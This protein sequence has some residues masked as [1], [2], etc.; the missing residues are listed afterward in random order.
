M[1]KHTS[2]SPLFVVCACIK[3]ADGALLCAR[4]ASHEARGGLWELP[5]GKV[6]EHE[7]AQGALKRE[8]L[9]ELSIEVAVGEKFFTHRHS[10]PEL[11]IDLTA[12]WCSII[13]GVPKALEHEEVRWVS[14]DELLLLDWAEADIPIVLRILERGKETSSL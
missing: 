6:K 5:G 11:T 13:H 2:A 4:R 14:P 12:F 7:T 9:E 3:R 1:A 8:L 10:Y